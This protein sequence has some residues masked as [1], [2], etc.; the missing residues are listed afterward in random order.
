AAPVL[1]TA[2]DLAADGTL[3]KQREDLKISA[4]LHR[5]Y[6]VRHW[7]H[8]LGPDDDRRFV[9]SLDDL[10][11]EPA[12]PM[13]TPDAPGDAADELPPGRLSLRQLT[14][15]GRELFEHEADLSADGSTLVTTWTVAHPRAATRIALIAIDT[16]TGERRTL[17]DDPTAEAEQPVISPDGKWVAFAHTTISSPDAAPVQRLA[18]VSIDGGEARIVTDAWDRWPYPAAWLPDSSAVVALADDDGRA[19]VFLVTLGTSPLDGEVRVD[20]VT[21]DDAVFSDA[22]VAPDGRTLYALRT[23]YTSPAEPV[24]IDLATFL[25]EPAGQRAPVAAGPLRGPVPAPA[26]PGTI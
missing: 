8:D 2:D 7:D 3:R 6:P 26:L 12:Q 17:F 20:R 16:A 5:G 25:A 13:P 19:P 4:I 14:G 15:A 18:I 9:A 24:R 10:F 22:I 23:S 11:D 21:A 1:A